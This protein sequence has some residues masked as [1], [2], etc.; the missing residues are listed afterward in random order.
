M[1]NQDNNN[2]FVFDLFEDMQRNNLNYIYRGLFTQ[3][4]TDNILLLT[5]TC[6][7]NV[8]EDSK[9]KKR[10]FT[11]LVEGLQNVTRHQEMTCEDES[12]KQS[13]IF[14]I[15]SQGDKYYITTGNPILKV[16]IP[17]L[18]KQLD[19]IN[20]LDADELKKFYKEVLNDNIISNKGG[21]GLGLIEMARKSGN[22]L[23]FDFS[24][25]NDDY[26]YFYIGT[27]VFQNGGA[28]IQT[29]AKKSMAAIKEIHK[30]INEQNI[31][32]IFNGIHTQDSLLHIMAIMEEHFG[33][34]E[35]KMRKCLIYTTIE[36]LQNIVKH[37]YK[38]E[39]HSTKGI[40][41]ISNNNSSYQLNTVN[42]I[43][44]DKVANVVQT[45]EELN[46]LTDA[47]L[48]DLYDK[49]LTDNV[50]DSRDIKGLGLTEIKLRTHNPIKCIVLQYNDEVSAI[51]MQATL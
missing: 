6:M 48:S 10:V 46:A 41:F 1:S 11:I 34:I 7:N 43:K 47:E 3:N 17:T 20:G 31:A 50:T 21:A 40:F 30:T 18:I 39:N 4:I 9:I 27:T 35:T 14:I 45:I 32:L 16:N 24:D 19:K 22:K 38:P 26:S 28:P 36:M 25:L 15:Q 12:T 2:S 51:C 49:N 37:G 33:N 42:Y 5:E 29:D 13:G 23:D 44:N 8:G